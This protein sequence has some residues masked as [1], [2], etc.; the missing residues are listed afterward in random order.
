MLYGIPP[1]VKGVLLLPLLSAVLALMLTA[2]LV[3]VWRRCVQTLAG[4][5]HYTLLVI[6]AIAFLWSLHYWRLL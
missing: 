1:L 6:A 5:L 2:L 3:P 4:R